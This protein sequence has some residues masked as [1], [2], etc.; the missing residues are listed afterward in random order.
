MLL[1]ESIG[2][3]DEHD[4][5]EQFPVFYK[6][7][8]AHINARLPRESAQIVAKQDT[9]VMQLDP[10]LPVMLFVCRTKGVKNL[11]AFLIYDGEA[12]CVSATRGDDFNLSVTGDWIYLEPGEYCVTKTALI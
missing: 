10:Q 1:N 9:P 2:Q 4:L 12:V 7:L 5:N 3:L 8:A 6:K 11:G